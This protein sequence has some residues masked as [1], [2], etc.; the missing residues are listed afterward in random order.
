MIRCLL[1]LLLLALPAAAQ[2]PRRMVSA[3]HPL[4]AAAGMQMLRDGGSAVDAAIA[5]QA[6]L[7]LVEPQSSGIGGGALL[8]HWDASARHLAA[9][10]G[11]EA[12]PASARP[13]MFLRDGRPLPFHAAAVG[14][15]AV[16]VP[17]T[18]RMLEAAH[19]AGGR[20]PWGALFAPAIALA[21]QGFP[22]SEKLARQAAADR[23]RLAQDPAARA[24]F[25][26]GGVPLA[27]GATLRNPALA[28]TLRAVAARGAS[29]LHE[30]PIAAAIAAAVRGHAGN[31]GGMTEA[32]LGAYRAVRRAPI[33]TPYRLYVV[34]GFPPPSS[35][36]VAVAQILGLLAHH[37]MAALAPL[38]VDAAALLGEAGR[39]AFADRNR[40]L[41][42]PDQVRVPL[43]G[44]LAPHYLTARAQLMRRDRALAE[45]PPGNP[46]WAPQGIAD[47]PPQ[48]ERGTAHMSIVDAAGNVVSMTTTI[49]NEFGA[50][51]M[52]GGFLLNN[53][54]TDF[55]FLP[56][57]EG[58]PVANRA[59]PGKRPRSSMSP[60]I[61]FGDG[62]PYAVVGSAGGGR[63]IGHVAQALVALLD[64]ELPPQQAAALPHVAAL[65]ARVELEQGTEAAA[66]A[67][68]L[69]ERGFPVEVRPNTS[70]L[71]LIRIGPS[72]LEGG[73][74]PR[75]EG[76]ALGD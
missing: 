30:G 42:D 20:L 29:A 26:P 37:D 62:R 9:W 57:I 55:S 35:G 8:L 1:A 69:R 45:V 58:R 48:P 4:A 34:C 40:Y 75:R 14:G 41:A 43:P 73:A 15:L 56:E 51:L 71:Q 23:D 32:D 36:G 27:Q 31:P 61:V 76:V 49:E 13:D 28:A 7:T 21:E 63:I 66:L 16:G 2:Q 39:L 33:C 22:V 17:G 52:V 24:Y 44:L 10:D 60:S 74:D 11:R 67:G 6:M 5:T 53:E 68:P 54:L 50:R 64:W 25:L 72:G 59:G 3:S 19:R 65:D 12:A 70:G 47:Q 18:L 38:S 46:P